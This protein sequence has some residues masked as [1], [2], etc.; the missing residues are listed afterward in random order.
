[1]ADD[2]SAPVDEVADG[3]RP[4]FVLVLGEP[5]SG[6][7]R[8][9]RRLARELRIPFLGR[10]D[11]R[12]GLWFTAGAWTDHPGPVPAADDAVEAFLVLAETLARVG[13]SCV[14]EYVIR[15]ARPQDLD[16]LTRVANC[17]G[18]WTSCSDAPA[19]VAAR[20]RADRLVNRRP[21]LDALG[22][23][24]IEEHVVAVSARMAGVTA[25]MQTTFDF[26]VLR[27]ETDGPYRPDLDQIVEFVA[28]AG[29]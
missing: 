27:V 25:E 2:V 20:D 12:T 28:R 26:P 1:V 6:K 21:V 9:G 16:R 17:I 7:S 14:V 23:G 18:I 24:S 19:R 4:T 22:H 13:V 5:G 8:L 11:V 29:R 10:D 3:G 15:E